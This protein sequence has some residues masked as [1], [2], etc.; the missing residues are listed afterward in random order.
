MTNPKIKRIGFCC[1]LIN[2]VD[3]V[4]GLKP[5]DPY[6][7][8]RFKTTTIKYLREN[9]SKVE[10]KLWDIIKH[11]VVAAKNIVSYVSKLAEPLRMLRLGSDIAPAYT[12]PDYEYFYKRSDVM[13]FMNKYL[14]EVG[15]IARNND[16]KL[17]FHPDQYVVICSDNDGIV[18][19]SLKELEYHTDIAKMMGYGLSKLDFKINVHLSGKKGVDGF[20]P[21]YNRMSPE[22]RN[23]LTL[24]NDEF[25]SSLDEVIK[26]KKYIGVVLDLHHHFIQSGEY[27]EASDPRIK[28]VIESWCHD[29]TDRR[30]SIHYSQSHEDLLGEH[31]RDTLPSLSTLIENGY[32]KTQLRAHSNN[33]WNTASNQWARSHWE[34]A[35]IMCESKE[36][37]LASNKL[38]EEFT[39][40]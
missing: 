36:K 20:I 15:N 4:G 1:H 39:K 12:H 13:S 9:S 8:Y 21:A 2:S 31:P 25:Q 22:L 3:Q 29:G 14:F 32:K 30:P 38:F 11:N 10:E 26:L 7:Q 16:V 5:H 34:Y 18:T 28:E 19:N 27:I 35:D 6:W 17:S 23:M 37:S 24:E 33:Y 40:K